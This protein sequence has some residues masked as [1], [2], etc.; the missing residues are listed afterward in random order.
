MTL[1]RSRRTDPSGELRVTRLQCQPILRML[2]IPPISFILQ[3]VAM[4]KAACRIWREILQRKL[5]IGAGFLGFDLGLLIGL[6]ASPVLG[7]TITGGLAL[8]GLWLK[9]KQADESKAAAPNVSSGEG[10]LTK[11]RSSAH[12]LE[13]SPLHGP[14]TQLPAVVPT[15]ESNRVHELR[16]VTPAVIPQHESPEGMRD[17]SISNLLLP[18]FFALPIGLFLGIW[19]RVSSAPS[20]NLTLHYLKL[21]F[22][23]NQVKSIMD[24][25][26][27]TI[28]GRYR[29][30][31]ADSE[32]LGFNKEQANALATRLLASPAIVPSRHSETLWSDAATPLGKSAHTTDETKRPPGNDGQ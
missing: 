7:T 15:P 20:P 13:I 5:A 11:T 19:L 6:S 8:F 29:D 27:K 4:Y 9:P 28:A 25:H 16:V 1:P 2:F 30:I 22:D 21:G 31:Y 3:V 10:S 14:V 32:D 26:A 17:V 24:H 12:G 18:V 23:P